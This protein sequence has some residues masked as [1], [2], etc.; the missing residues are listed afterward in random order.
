MPNDR[1]DAYIGAL[2]DNITP[3]VQMVLCVCPSS[4]KDRYDAIKKI[5]C[6]DHPGECECIGGFVTS[7]GPS[8]ALVSVT[9]LAASE[10][11]ENHVES[12]AVGRAGLRHIEALST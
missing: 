11:S 8:D 10:T 9:H 4:K 2:R 6:I 12:K 5:C 7:D 3:N 1:N